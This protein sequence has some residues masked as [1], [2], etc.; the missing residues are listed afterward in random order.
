MYI[1]TSVK[2]KNDVMGWVLIHSVTFF[3]IIPFS[4]VANQTYIQPTFLVRFML[5][6]IMFDYLNCGCTSLWNFRLS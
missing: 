3:M 2:A 6:S 1:S 4:N 5:G